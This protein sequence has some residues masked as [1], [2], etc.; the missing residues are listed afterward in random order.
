M[1]VLV[2]AALTSACGPDDV[3]VVDLVESLPRA[4]LFVESALIDVGTPAGR[5][6]L[7]DGFLGAD[8]MWAH[9]PDRSFVWA[10][11]SAATV[12]FFVFEPRD[13][14]LLLTARPNPRQDATAVSG[15]RPVV[16]GTPLPRQEVPPGW[17]TQRIVV[18]R[19]ALVAGE[20]RLTLSF[21]D[22]EGAD[23][24][25]RLAVDR[26]EIE[27]T[28]VTY[29]PRRELG[30]TGPALLV[31]YLSGAWYRLEVP[32]GAHLVID[33]VRAYGPHDGDPEGTLEIILG[34]PPDATRHTAPA[35][36]GLDLPLPAGPLRLALLAVPGGD[37][38]RR[39]D[40]RQNEEAV[41][42]ILRRPRILA[43]AG[44]RSGAG[45]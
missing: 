20:N 7:G 34:E 22:G 33:G 32:D 4:E 9:R 18:P 45:G 40:R 30:D 5:P 37:A 23:V 8:E 28:V 25:R 38:N 43:P 17:S 35:G 13:L 27:R 3:E 2:A 26:L 11:G 12:R 31:P 39:A 41:G 42:L 15:F 44:A 21:D 29:P 6:H 19:R 24:D 10:V 1:V 16:N 36:R 14:L